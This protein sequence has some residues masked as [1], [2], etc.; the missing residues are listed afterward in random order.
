MF[1]NEW[2]YIST[3]PSTPSW[4]KQEQLY[5]WGKEDTISISSTLCC[6]LLRCCFEALVY[7]PSCE[8]VSSKT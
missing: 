4:R 3:P 1:K 2:S 7:S 6:E 8:S 5:M